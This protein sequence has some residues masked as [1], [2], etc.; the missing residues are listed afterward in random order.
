M[1]ATDVALLSDEPCSRT[2]AETNTVPERAPFHLEDLERM[3]L[4]RDDVEGLAGFES[5][6]LRHGYWG[7]GELRTL[8]VN[9]PSTCELMKTHGRINGFANAYDR[10][11][12]PSQ[13]A[14]FAVHLFWNG[15]DA[16]A[17]NDAFVND[18]KASVGKPEGPTRFEM[19]PVEELGPGGLVGEHEGPDGIRSWAMFVRG[20]I[21][22]WVVDLH[23]GARPHFDVVAAARTMA[24]RVDE[25]A[26]DAE[27]RGD[28]GVDAAQVLSGPLTLDDWGDR[29]AGLEWDPF[30]GGCADAEERAAIAGEEEA[31][32]AR[33]FGRIT[34][35]TS[36][37]SPPEGTDSEI[38]R[39]F[40]S[41]Q[42]FR[43]EQGA[44]ADLDDAV[45][46]LEARGGQRFTVEPIG[47]AAVGVVQPPSADAGYTQ[48]RVLFRIDDVLASVALH[49]ESD[50]D[51]RAE[52]TAL[53]Q[54]LEARL[55]LLERTASG[56][57][58]QSVD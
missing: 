35:C 25:V 48:T 37:Y 44:A 29:Y 57:N 42:V 55:L 3:V 45:K 22:G 40:S 38:V 6:M 46:E 50:R 11:T 16:R 12:Q 19:R 49:D 51:A 31:E 23:Q 26:A 58:D 30:F 28:T 8:E 24:A 39:V 15:L 43:D 4:E 32:D 56:S 1:P 47:D 18:T 17:W 41:M 33:T 2:I 27:R 20:P 9:P 14:T 10:Y 34:G 54:K 36:M 13:L 21:V 52:L 7:N 5:D 53:A